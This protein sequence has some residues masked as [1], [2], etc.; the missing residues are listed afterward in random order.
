M[1]PGTQA[2][3]R[4]VTYFCLASQKQASI[5]SY[6]DRMKAQP[7]R[8]CKIWTSM[9]IYNTVRAIFCPAHMKHYQ[10]YPN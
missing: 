9:L 1:N 4:I 7:A 2:S 3:G 10:C 6:G 5:K 8:Y